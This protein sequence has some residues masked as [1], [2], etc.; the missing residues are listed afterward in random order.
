MRPKEF[1]Y[2]VVL[3]RR[4][5]VTY[6]NVDTG[7]LVTNKKVFVSSKEFLIE[8][9]YLMHKL[10]L[11][12][13]KKEKDRQRLVKLSK[14]FV[15]NIKAGDSIETVFRRVRS[16]IVKKRPVTRK[17]GKVSMSRAAKI[18]PNKYKQYTSE[19]SDERL[20]K[21]FVHGLKTSS[22]KMKVSGYENTSGNKR[23]NLESLRWKNVTNNSYVKNEMNLRTKNAKSIP[24]N[25]NV[26]KTL[27]GHNPRRNK[28]VP[29]AVVNKAAAIPFVGLKK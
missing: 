13:E 28:W 24:K 9:I 29:N 11:R 18:N 8:D 7:K 10:K 12:P 23:F 4:R 3:T 21:Q 20:S 5:G 2:E 15:K 17:D 14:L 6:R 25:L 22:N 26:S 1:G 19:P 27:Y 16:K